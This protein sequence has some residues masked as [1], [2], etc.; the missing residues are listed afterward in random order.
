M[1]NINN[2]DFRVTT[3][4]IL[5][6]TNREMMLNLIRERQPIF[7]AAQTNLFAGNCT[8][9]HPQAFRLPSVRILH[10]RLLTC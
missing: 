3:R 4:T 10:W 5:R 9:V 6:E 1:R 2:R 7:R 8:T